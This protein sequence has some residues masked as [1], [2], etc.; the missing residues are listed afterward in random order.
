LNVL[1]FFSG[2][3]GG[4]FFAGRW[5]LGWRAGGWGFCGFV[6]GAA[7]GWLEGWRL[8]GCVLHWAF[9]VAFVLHW[10]LCFCVLGVVL[11]LAFPFF[12]CVLHL[13]W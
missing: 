11:L 4:G 1:F 2:E 10:V 12:S 9:F 8:G 5:W 7:G 3:G 6:L 13:G